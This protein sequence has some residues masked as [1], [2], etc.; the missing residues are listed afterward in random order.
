MRTLFRFV[1]TCCYA[2]LFLGFFG[3]LALRIRGFDSYLAFHL[4]FH[5]RR[6]GLVLMLAG[7]ALAAL[8]AGTFVIKGRGTPAVFDPPRTFVAVGPYRY[9][10]N[11]MYVGGLSLLIGF[12]LYLEST[13]VLIF[14][15]V[16]CLVVHGFV[17]LVEEPGL[18]KRFG[19]S[20]HQYKLPVN[21]WFP[22]WR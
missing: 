22:K 9:V 11:P 15:V 12:G 7:G 10:R 17:V 18:E 21:R 6:L 1:R 5:T 14:G 4:P 16:L 2:G 8:C 13:S 20:Y 3:W 19:E